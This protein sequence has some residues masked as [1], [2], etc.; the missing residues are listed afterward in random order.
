MKNGA[1]Y[2]LLH[3]LL[4]AL[5]AVLAAGL[6]ACS[7]GP[8][9]TTS[10]KQTQSAAVKLVFTTQPAGAEAGAFLATPPI[11]AAVDSNGNVVAGSHRV[12]TL[13][14][15]GGTAEPPVTLFGGTTMTSENGIFAFKELS[16]DKAGTYTLTATSSGLTPAVSDPFTITPIHGARLVF[17]TKI[18]GAS[19]GAGFAAQPAVTVLDRYDNTAYGSTAM[20]SLSLVVVTPESYDAILS[21]VTK[22]KAVNG[23]ASFTGLSVNRA[24][25]Y[26]LTATSSSLTP[27]YSNSFNIGPGTGIKLFFNTQPLTAA[28]GEPLTVMPPTIAVLVQDAYGNTATDS[29]AEIT[30]TITPGTGSSGAVLSGTTQLKATGGTACFEGLSINTVGNGYTLTATSPALAPAVSELFDITPPEPPPASSNT[31]SP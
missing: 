16:V 5:T 26:V 6:I 14:I 17:S 23:A 15:T 9:P 18:A 22:L 27:A 29:S 4:A 19:A 24:G 10:S 2:L 12:I 1:G 8:S 20:V 7:P 13:A 11:V 21:G 3:G 30:L 31:T 28:A 25:T